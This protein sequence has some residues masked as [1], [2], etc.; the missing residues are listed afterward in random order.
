ML[1]QLLATC[2]RTARGRRDALCCCLVS[3]AR[4]AAPTGVSP[5]RRCRV[6]ANGLRLRIL[7]G[8]T[9][10]EGQGAEIGLPR[11]RQAETCPLRAFETG[12]RWRC[13]KRVAVSKNQRE[14]AGRRH[15][16]ASGRHSAFSPIAS[17]WPG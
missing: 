17:A 12:R 14:R 15:R 9:D 3:P 1:R 16:D 11:G 10:Q 5:R 7:R 6:D 4:S 13:G 8:K 2:D